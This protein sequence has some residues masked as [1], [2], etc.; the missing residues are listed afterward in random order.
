VF[1]LFYI[2][3]KKG[4]HIMIILNFSHPLT[5]EQLAQIETLTASPISEVR[6]EMA[7]LDNALPF[8]QQVRGMVERVGL[9]SD[10]WQTGPLLVNLPGYAP[11]VGVLLAELHGRMGHFPSILRVRPVQG[12]VPRRF[13]VAEVLDLQA[14]REVAREQR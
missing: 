5:S 8:E 14:I 11:A 3:Y 10:E 13:E 2:P 7:K 12:A 1:Y 4:G 9:S 6:G